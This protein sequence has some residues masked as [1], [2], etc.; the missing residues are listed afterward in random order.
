MAKRQVSVL[1]EPSPAPSAASS[2]ASSSSANS[3]SSSERDASSASPE[4]AAA[5]AAVAAQQRQKQHNASL[6]ASR[7]NPPKGFKQAQSK[8]DKSP[9]DWNDIAS[10]PELELWAVRVPDNIKLSNLDG[11]VLKVPDSDSTTKPLVTF[12]PGKSSTEYDVL[13]ADSNSINSS[14]NSLGKRKRQDAAAETT[15]G[16]TAVAVN[17]GSEMQSFVALLP[18]HSAGDKLYQ[19][20]R[21]I[22]KSLVITR[23][24]PAN[25]ASKRASSSLIASQPS[26]VPG[27]ILTA[28]EL[29]LPEVVKEKK[30]VREQPAG[31][32]M[33]ASMPG[34]SSSTKVQPKDKEDEQ[35]VREMDVD[36]EPV[37]K[38]SKQDRK[39][40]KE[41]KDKKDKKDK[42]ARKD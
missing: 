35:R 22:T 29:L 19:A 9:V 41:K 6:D 24:L 15:S 13:I 32:K 2:E 38:K 36:V 18:K 12:K 27:A 16:D 37:A 21:S 42:K 8:S 4:P 11:I 39:D 5:Q 25:I 10:N 34:L 20:P 31:L 7:Y 14:S 17:G 30:V 3:T 33:R 26:P 28:D 23:H 1:K 40:K